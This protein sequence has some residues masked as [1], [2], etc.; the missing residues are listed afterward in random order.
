MANRICRMTL[1][2]L[3]SAGIGIHFGSAAE[4]ASI[5]LVKD[6]KSSYTIVAPASPT[7]QE[8]LAGEELAK[9]LKQI[10]GAELAIK[11]DAAGR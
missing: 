5:T 11:S 6:G 4:P 7:P 10:A 8:K 2:I 9:Y 1:A 3:V